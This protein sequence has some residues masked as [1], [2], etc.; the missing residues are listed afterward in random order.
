MQLFHVW[1]STKFRGDALQDERR[2]IVL[3]AFNRIAKDNEIDLVESEAQFDH[4]HLLLRVPDEAALPR[5]MML[6]KGISAREV[7]QREPELRMSMRSLVFWQKSFGRRPIPEDQLETVRKYIRLNS[8]ARFVTKRCAYV[9]SRIEAEWVQPSEP[10]LQ[11]S[12]P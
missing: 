4:V 2:K 6:L 11:F 12:S 8:I 1:F 7:F 5:A 9:H 3:D 10:L